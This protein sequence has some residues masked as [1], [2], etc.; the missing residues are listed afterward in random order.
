MM[1]KLDKLA[2]KWQLSSTQAIGILPAIH[3]HVL[4]LDILCKC[5][6]PSDRPSFWPSFKPSC[7]ANFRLLLVGTYSLGCHPSLLSV[8]RPFGSAFGCAASL[9]LL[10]FTPWRPP[11]GQGVIGASRYRPIWSL[12][13]QLLLAADGCGESAQIKVRKSLINRL[14]RCEFQIVKS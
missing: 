7:V 11:V 13:E 6:C 2:R 9:A 14:G 10:L 4:V 5:T 1:A 8:N 3:F 12:I